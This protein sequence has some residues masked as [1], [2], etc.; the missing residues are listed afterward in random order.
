MKISYSW[1]KDFVDVDWSAEE[2]AE[3]LTLCGLEVEETETFESLK[4]GLKGVVVGEVLSAEK[5]PNAD[6]LRVCFVDIGKQK[7]CI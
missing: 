4:G 7:C 2:M 1:L 3:R 5:H 6:R